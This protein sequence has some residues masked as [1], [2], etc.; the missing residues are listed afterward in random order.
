MQRS[1]IVTRNTFLYGLD[2]GFGFISGVICSVLVARAM[3]P[4]ILGEYNYITWI[5]FTAGILT[6]LGLPA[7]ARKYA[8]EY[9]GAGRPD[10]AEAVIRFT[11]WLQGLLGVALAAAGLVLARSMLTPLQFAYGAPAVVALIPVMSMSA[12]SAANAAREDLAPNALASVAGS[13]V[14]LVLTLATLRFGWGLPGLTFAILISRVVD[15]AVR[16]AGFRLRFGAIL[17][18][19]G[20]LLRLEGFAGA[21]KLQ[22]FRFCWE[23]LL[24]LVIQTVVWGRSEVWFLQRFWPSAE[25]SFYSLGFNFTDKVNMIPLAVAGAVSASLMV[26]FGR[27]A[28]GAGLLALTSLRYLA[29][30]ALPLLAGLAAIGRPLVLALY[31]D[32][33]LPAVLPLMLQCVLLMPRALMSP[34]NDLLVAADRQRELFRWGLLMCAI[35]LGLDYWWIRGGGAMGAAW[36]NGIAQSVAT[37]GIWR[38]AL[39]AYGLSF[40]LGPILRIASASGMMGVAVWAITFRL[41]PGTALALGVPAGA[42]LYAVF[43]RMTRSLDATDQRR[44]MTIERMLPAPLRPAYGALLARV[45]G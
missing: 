38:L 23:A 40:P 22:F 32:R 5:I 27:G 17:W 31:G 9:Y 6:S 35:N 37:V 13:I 3:G 1:W 12:L 26:E 14:T 8:G 44:L 20:A 4:S 21:E 7:A 45:A 43:L 29:L 25:V 42:V 39:R 24:L 33:F 15:L 2:L 30:V 11:F 41:S 18:K 10:K 16:Y 28:R 19:P 36:A 34:G